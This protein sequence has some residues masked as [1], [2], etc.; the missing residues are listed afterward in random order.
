[1]GCQ[2][3][4]VINFEAA[5][6]R[7]LRAAYDIQLT[8]DGELYEV[9]C[10]D[11]D[12]LWRCDAP[13]GDRRYLVEDGVGRGGELSLRVWRNSGDDPQ[14]PLE[15]TATVS[16]DGATVGRE[17]F[18]PEYEIEFPNGEGCGSCAVTDPVWV[19]IDDD[20]TDATPPTG[21]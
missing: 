7:N 2:S 14:A 9:A 17:T 8:L 18:E 16:S 12:G 4:L 3:G 5:D 10:V 19:T 20:G 1:M 21:G 13:D 6:D 11:D 15:V